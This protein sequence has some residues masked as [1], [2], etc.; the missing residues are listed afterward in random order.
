MRFFL[1]L[2][3]IISVIFGIF[4]FQNDTK[5]TVKFLT[6]SLSWHLTI[7]LLV[8][9]IVGIITGMLLLVPTV[10]KKAAN[11]RTYKKRIRELEEESARMS[12]TVAPIEQKGE[13]EPVSEEIINRGNPPQ[14]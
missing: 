9:F 10:W 5:I 2:I 14:P 7:V 3:I 1:I 6:W 11:A 4:T 8:P 12:E 13:S